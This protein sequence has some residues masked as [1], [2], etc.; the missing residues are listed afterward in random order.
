MRRGEIW[1]AHLPPPRGSEPGHRRPVVVVQHDEFNSSR[2]GTVIV[3]ALTTQMQ[4][5][6]D[7][8]NLRLPKSVT[9]LPKTSVANVSAI[10]TI[11]KDSLLERVS[12]LPALAMAQ[13]DEGLRLV[14][15]L[16]RS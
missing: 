15:D 3:I 7:P 2:I 16:D 13:I 11:N 4:R 14:L 6:R 1:W 9:K 12:M 8:G 5:E 10:I